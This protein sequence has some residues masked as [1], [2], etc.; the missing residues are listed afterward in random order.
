MDKDKTKKLFRKFSII[1]LCFF[2]PAAAFLLLHLDDAIPSR[3][4]AAVV[5]ELDSAVSITGQPFLPFDDSSEAYAMG[6]NAEGMPVFKDP[7]QAFIQIKKDY[8]P[9]IKE[10]QKEFKLKP[11]NRFYWRPYETY[12]WQMSTS[13]PELR[14][15]GN[16]VCRFISIY[17]NSFD[18]IILD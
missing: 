12:G 9:G 6:V 3:Q 13:D 18:N 7:D 11:F 4:K 2:I 8:T 17:K 10:L 16:R 1:L 15:Q 14:Y 5:G